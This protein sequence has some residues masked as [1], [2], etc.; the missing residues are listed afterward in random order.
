VVETKEKEWV[1][2]ANDRCDSGC[3]AQAYV[4]VKGVDGELLFCVHHYEKIMSN[5]TGYEKMISFAMEI[6]D[7]REKLVENR[8][9]ADD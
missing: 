7:E 6:V 3:N 9:K 1:L 4:W 8:L 5:P 2:N